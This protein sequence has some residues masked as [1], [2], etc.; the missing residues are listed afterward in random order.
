MNRDEPTDL[1]DAWR[2]FDRI[3]S[4]QKSSQTAS[5]MLV[6]HFGR[7]PSERREEA[8]A[9]V[10]KWLDSEDDKKRFDALVLVDHF[11]LVE[12]IPVIQVML[13]RAD[14]PSTGPERDETEKLVQTLKRLDGRDS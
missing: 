10:V 5:L 13:L 8:V 9:T 7:L 2:R 11:L 6:D 12:A 3:A 14:R 1:E 4:Q